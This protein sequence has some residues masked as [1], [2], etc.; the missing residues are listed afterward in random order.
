MMIRTRARL[1]LVAAS[2]LAAAACESAVNSNDTDE[3]TLSFSYAGDHSGSFS[4]TG[5][6]DRLRPNASPW[7][8][9]NRGTLQTGQTAIGVYAR[10]DRTGDNLVDEFLLLIEEPEVGSVTCTDVTADCP[11]GAFLILG[12]TPNGEEALA[13]YASASGTVNITAINQDRATGN[14]V[15]TMEGFNVEDAAD[16]VQVT[17]GTFSVPVIRAVN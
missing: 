9:G 17:S 7:A 12:T 1:A 15:F 10:A 4:A 6:Y 2:L 16:S 8:V 14:F 3:G 11:M 13:I 5:A